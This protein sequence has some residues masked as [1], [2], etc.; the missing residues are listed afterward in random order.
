M[1]FFDCLV[2][3]WTL[4]CGPKAQWSNSQEAN[5]IG[6]KQFQFWRPCI[7]IFHLAYFKSACKFMRVRPLQGGTVLLF[8]HKNSRVVVAIQRQ[9]KT[10]ICGYGSGQTV[11]KKAADS[12]TFLYTLSFSPFWPPN[13]PTSNFRFQPQSLK[14]AKK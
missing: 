11:G 9:K 12:P 8:H 1:K 5:F 14:K 3:F 4:L 13:K 2:K 10:S 6:F 7:C